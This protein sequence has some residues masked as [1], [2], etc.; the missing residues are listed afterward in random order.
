MREHLAA[1]PQTQWCHA[2]LPTA[3][4][5]ALQS[6]QCT[7]P[8]YEPALQLHQVCMVACNGAFYTCTVHIVL[9]LK[10]SRMVTCRTERPTQFSTYLELVISWPV[11]LPRHTL[12]DR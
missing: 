12:T 3:S 2:C 7:L 6:L 1:K 5:R 8:A 10:S 4:T 9:L 11:G